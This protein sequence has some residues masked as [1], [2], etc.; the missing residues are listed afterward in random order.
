MLR[1]RGFTLLELVLV[2]VLLGILSIT[3]YGRWGGTSEASAATARDQLLTRLRL[4]QLQNMNEPG[5]SSDSTARCSWL[6]ID[7]DRFVTVQTS[8]RPDTCATPA[9]QSSMTTTALQQGGQ[10]ILDGVTMALSGSTAFTLH[11]DR[12]GRPLGVCSN[13]CVLIVGSNGQSRQITINA[14][15]YMEAD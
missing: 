14:Q 2:I 6:R 10:L 7:V 1:G 5:L 3:A 4:V 15:G 9:A 13:G 12:M 8:G 11:F